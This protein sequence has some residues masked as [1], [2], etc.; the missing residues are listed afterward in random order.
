MEL[1]RLVGSSKGAD[2]VFCLAEASSLWFAMQASVFLIYGAD[3][4]TLEFGAV[5]YGYDSVRNII[6][7]RQCPQQGS[8]RAAKRHLG[9]ARVLCPDLF[10]TSSQQTRASL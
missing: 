10:S 7:G 9:I 3:R 5:F 2:C 8:K 4:M 1:E 6:I